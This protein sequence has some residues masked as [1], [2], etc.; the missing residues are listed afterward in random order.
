MEA[1]SVT[2]SLQKCDREGEKGARQQVV[3]L[4]DRAEFQNEENQRWAKWF[5]WLLFRLYNN[6]K[7]YTGIF[8]LPPA[9]YLQ[10][11]LII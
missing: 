6:S 11:A 1:A 9:C 8:L 10:M 4:Q 2:G 7:Q 3:G 5:T